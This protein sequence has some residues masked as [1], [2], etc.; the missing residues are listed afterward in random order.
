[1]LVLFVIVGT[2]VGIEAGVGSRL[3]ETIPSTTMTTTTTN[4]T[5]VKFPSAKGVAYF[6]RLAKKGLEGSFS[7]T[8]RASGSP[9]DEDVSVIHVAQRASSG[10]SPWL[11]GIGEWSYRLAA[12]G[13]FREQWIQLSDVA[14]EDCWAAPPD[15]PLTCSATSE[16][17]GSIGSGMSMYAFLPG[18]EFGV[19]EETVEAGV[20][21]GTTR[22]DVFHTI[23]A[24]TLGLLV[25]LRATTH[26]G[27]ET[28]CLTQEGFLA[29]VKVG[30]PAEFNS[31]KSVQLV[32]RESSVTAGEFVPEG[33]PKGPFVQLPAG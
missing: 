27:P 23:G 28:W 16:F 1:M 17:S 32:S 8:Y 18:G 9:L 7:A 4:P 26:V 2:G 19:M 31:W 22:L 5:P 6:L 15:H 3:T 29:S 33:V 30:E 21:G 20:A 10:Q 24:G 25:C 12:S 13:G 14:A 11:N